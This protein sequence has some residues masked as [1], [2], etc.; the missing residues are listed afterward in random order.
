MEL[1]LILVLF[2]L[3]SILTRLSSLTHVS[4]LLSLH[5]SLTFIFMLT[6]TLSVKEN[7][8]DAPNKPLT[9]TLVFGKELQR[10]ASVVKALP[11]GL[12]KTKFR[13]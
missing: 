11:Q 13:L 5:A 9:N 10:K 2:A 6:A 12:N 3:S 8:R 7:R 1:T 4:V